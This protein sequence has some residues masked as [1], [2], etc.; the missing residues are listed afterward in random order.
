MSFFGCL[1]RFAKFICVD[2]NYT[3][4]KDYFNLKMVSKLF[5]LLFTMH[6]GTKLDI[7]SSG[8]LNI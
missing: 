2:Q 1:A 4:N 8:M 6:T 5:R 7:I 3:Q